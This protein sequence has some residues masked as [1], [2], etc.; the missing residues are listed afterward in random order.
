MEKEPCLPQNPQSSTAPTDAVA[1]KKRHPWR[2]AGL[3]LL[4]VG[5]FFF[6]YYLLRATLQ[7][8]IA[9]DLDEPKEKP[10]SNM[11]LGW[12]RT[13]DVAIVVSGQMEGYLQPC[14]C[15]SPQKGGL[16]RRYNFIE[17]LKKKGWPVAAVDLGDI[18]Q[19]AGP[20]QRLKYDVSMKALKAMG[21]QAV[22]IGKNEFLMPLTDALA[23]YSIQNAKPRPVVT[24]LANTEKEGELFFD[25][26]VRKYEVFQAGTLKLGVLGAVSAGRAKKIT[27][28]LP[29]T[30][31]EIKF[32]EK[33]A[34]RALT[35]LGSQKVDVGI[36][37][38]HGSEKE[39][40]DCAELLHKTRQ[41]EAGFA[42]VQIMVCSTNI[43]EPPSYAVKDSKF[44]NTSIIT[45]G[46]RGKY[47]GVVGVWKTDKG[48]DFKY[49]LVAIGPEYETKEG[50]EKAN[51]ISGL[52][53][54]YAED[55]RDGNYLARFPRGHHETQ[56]TFKDAKY[57]GSDR[58]AGC[59]AAADKVWAGSNHARAFATLV[60]KAKQP[61][62]R[63]F[64]GECVVCHTVGFKYHT[65]Y[66]DPPRG[67][68]PKQSEKH[69]AKL[70]NVGCESCH[71]PG[72][73]HTNNPQNQA[74]YPY[75][76]PYRP[77]EKERDPKTPQKV[78]EELLRKRMLRI[79]TFCQTCHDMDNDVH[80]GETPFAEKWALIAHPTPQN[81]PNK[82]AEK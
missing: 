56:A 22:G 60:H 27:E 14:G 69:N 43:D 50:H 49:Q 53:E 70:L 7:N 33:Q 77:T 1:G 37:L 40:M 80:W 74:L 10:P 46:H 12:N 20:Q 13:P 81:A 28:A 26:N 29:P 16:A 9:Q 75:I 8:G 57:V 59:H 21:Y 11:F 71:G 34:P 24:N 23:E 4:M 5:A 41:T 76:N 17:S 78:K 62:L 32:L 48:L 19:P 61:T 73:N 2:F 18:A 63:Q 65:G 55:A 64:D 35:E 31:R 68:T 30:E 54:K 6:G 36:L 39:A 66:Y 72:S 25:L 38:Y 67:A 58:C 44:P 15:S 82:K 45:V 52:L 47:V 42:P 51:P 79:D 3:A